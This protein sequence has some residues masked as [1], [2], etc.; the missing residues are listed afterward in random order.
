MTVVQD[1]ES[2]N[3]ELVV[4]LPEIDTLIWNQPNVSSNVVIYDVE[5]ILKNMSG[6]EDD[7]VEMAREE[8]ETLEEYVEGEFVGSDEDEDIDDDGDIQDINS[9]NE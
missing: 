8:D 4:E 5:S 9:D 1:T 3:V 7:E 2:T 6:A